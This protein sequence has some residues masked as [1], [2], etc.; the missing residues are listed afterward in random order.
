E[1]LE[2]AGHLHA[3]GFLSY[4]AG[5]ALEPKLAPLA[6]ASAE[7]DPPLLWFG[8]FERIEEGDVASWLPEPAGAWSGAP[9]PL[10]APTDYRAAV[11]T[12]LDHIGAGDIYQANLTFPAEVP[13]AGHPLALYAGIRSRAR[14]GH[15]GLL[16][17]GSHWLLSF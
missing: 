11:A 8:L 1:R 3:A 9:R 5:H 10:I 2:Q 12:V 13:V 16:F 4:E 6:R 15:A 14:A 7:G 17:T